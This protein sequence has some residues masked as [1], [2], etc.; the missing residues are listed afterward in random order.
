MKIYTKTGDQGETGL[1]GGSRVKK[2]HARIE[3]YGTLDELNAF[4]GLLRDHVASTE[5]RD[6]LFAVQNRLFSIG[7]YLATPQEEG[8]VVLPLDLHVADINILEEAMDKMDQALPALRNFVLPGGHP[9]VSHAHVVRT[10]CRRAER[11]CVSILEEIT[12][13]PLV[14]QYLNRL[15]DYFFVLGRFLAQELNA[16]EVTWQMR[17]GGN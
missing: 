2:N 5:I 15:S 14:L 12:I 4:V 8:K 17:E 9:T 7:S 13:D 1:F 10:V 3:A 11:Q 16:E 6:T